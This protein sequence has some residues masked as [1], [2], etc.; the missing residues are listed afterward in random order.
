M[1]AADLNDADPAAP[2]ASSGLP[3][4]DPAAPEGP[5]GK[6]AADLLAAAHQNLVDTIKQRMEY[7]GGLW[8]E[9]D[10]WAL[11]DIGT[12]TA[13]THLRGATLGP[14]ADARTLLA[15]MERRGLGTDGAWSLRLHPQVGPTAY[16]VV[17][18]A[19][20]TCADPAGYPIMAITGPVRRELVHRVELAALGPDGER[21]AA[22]AIP[23]LRSAFTALSDS[24]ARAI[25]V[26]R[27]W[28]TSSNW[29]LGI[30]RAEGDCAGAEESVEGDDAGTPVVCTGMLTQTAGSDTAGLYYISTDPRERGKGYAK[31]LCTVL[32]NDAFK[33]GARAVILQASTLG[34]FVYDH[35]GYQEI[36]RYYTYSRAQ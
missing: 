13:D 22:D 20:F 14:R 9:G 7:A 5:A 28:T 17:E 31:D 21:A 35:L 34:K 10:D 19:G 18:S 33:R 23:A 2:A 27:A 16:A 3:T 29:R 25:L 6:L 32:T 8:V 36:G 26:P 1:D 4:A 24:D 30:V 12:T 15:E 11:Y